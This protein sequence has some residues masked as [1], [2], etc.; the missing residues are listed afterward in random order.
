MKQGI[1]RHNSQNHKVGGSPPT[2]PVVFPDLQRFAKH[3]SRT[4]VIRDLPYSCKN[5][6]LRQFLE[7]EHGFQVE[8]VHVC[9]DRKNQSLHYGY[10]LFLSDE[11]AKDVLNKLQGQRMW[12]RDLR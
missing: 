3:A 9:S 8:C 12:G 5:D 4:L 1:S 10:A 6:H 7:V 11:M 2:A